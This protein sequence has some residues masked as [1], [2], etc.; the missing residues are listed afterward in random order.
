MFRVSSE[1]RQSEIIAELRRAYWMFRGRDAPYRV[2]PDWEKLA[3]HIKDR[4]IVPSRYVRWAYMQIR[5]SQHTPWVRQITSAG[6]VTEFLKV[7]KEYIKMEIL[8]L[9]LRLKMLYQRLATGVT[10]Q[11]VIADEWLDLGDAVRYAAARKA[12]M[13]DSVERLRRG[14]ELDL[15]NEPVYMS[16]LSPF[17]G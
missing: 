7:E 17:L 3:A 9:K 2:N 5:I 11:Q 10:V 16:L 4:A 15:L 12:G 8:K 1:C 13:T 14:A 6:R